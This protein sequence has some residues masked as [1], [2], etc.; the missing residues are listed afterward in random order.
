M[1]SLPPP[2]L[3]CARAASSADGALRQPQQLQP[4]QLL[5]LVVALTLS[6]ALALAQAG[7]VRN[8]RCCACRVA[9]VA[10]VE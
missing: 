10:C 9:C 3:F 1:L 4:Q 7:P 6:L 2:L 5:L 8:A